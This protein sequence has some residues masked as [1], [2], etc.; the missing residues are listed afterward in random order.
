MKP[1]DVE[2]AKADVAVATREEVN[3]AVAGVEEAGDN[4][5]RRLE[6]QAQAFKEMP[7]DIAALYTAASFVATDEIDF[8]RMTRERGHKSESVA[9]AGGRIQV[10]VQGIGEVTIGDFGRHDA[11]LPAKKHRMIAFFVPME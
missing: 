1:Y 9:I 4:A 11:I 6:V 5:A 10:F 8:G 2:Q 3:R 7:K